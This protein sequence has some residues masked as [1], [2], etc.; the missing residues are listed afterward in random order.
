MLNVIS[1]LLHHFKQF[2][3]QSLEK[4]TIENQISSVVKA[5]LFYIYFNLFFDLMFFDI[6][7]K[8]EVTYIKNKEIKGFSIHIFIKKI[9]IKCIFYI[10]Y[11][12][13]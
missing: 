4:F 7:N 5:I 13:I 11:I 8:N 10:M 1:Y 9:I 12:N 2:S 6:R 3:K